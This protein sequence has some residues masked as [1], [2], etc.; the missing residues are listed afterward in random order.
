MNCSEDVLAH[1]TGIPALVRRD[2]PGTA[3]TDSHG[4][5]I[6][7]APAALRPALRD[8]AHKEGS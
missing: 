3:N 7:L 8:K 5:F 6:S 1:I 4:G 2:L